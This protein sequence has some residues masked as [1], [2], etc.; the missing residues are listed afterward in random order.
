MLPTKPSQTTTSTRSLNKSWPSTLPMKFKSSCLQSLKASSV[1]SLPLESSGADAQDAD[2]RVFAA[3]NFTR[4]N[5]AHHRVMGQMN[6]FA[7]D[8]RAGIEQDEL[9][10]R[11]GNDGGNAAAIHAGNAA[12]LERGRREN[13][14][15]VAERNNRISFSVIDQFDCAHNRAILFLRTATGRFVLHRQH[16]AGM[17]DAHA[18]ITKAA[19]RQSG[20]NFGGI[21]DQEEGGD[22]LVGLESPVGAFD[23]DPATVVATHDIHCDSHK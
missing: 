16:L 23:D 5:A 12:Q 2:A 18:M 7:F 8:V 20:V 10:F 22:L 3:E 6:R 9:A 21:A 15:G 13:A 11:R 17:D 1:S 14:A 19:T 4:I